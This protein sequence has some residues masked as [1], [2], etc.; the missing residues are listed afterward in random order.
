MNLDF[1]KEI[2]E[3]SDKNEKILEELI[4]IQELLRIIIANELLEDVD[5]L[6]QE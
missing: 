5:I 4:G 3:V 2:E 6:V 1:K